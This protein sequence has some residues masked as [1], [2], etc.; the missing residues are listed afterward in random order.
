MNILLINHYA[1]STSYG[2]EYRPFYMARE[3]VKLGHNVTIVGGSYSHVRTEQPEI[4]G[5]VTEENVDGIRYVWLKTP[6][7]RGNGTRRVLNIFSFVF[8][9]WWHSRRVAGDFPP[10]VVIASSTYPLDIFPANRIAE[11]Y[12]A[13]LLFEVH[14]LWPLTPIQIGGMSP[15]HP[16]IML[17]QYA[18][19]YAY[20]KS[21]RVISMLP[22]AFEYMRKHGLV[23][24]KFVHI[25]NGINT[26]EWEG[27]LTQLP[28]RHAECLQSFRN[29]G[30]FIIGYVGGH[31]P[32]NA[33]EA[34]LKAAEL[35]R[36]APAIFV[37]VGKGSEKEHL[38]RSA[39]KR[40][41]SNVVFLPP[42]PKAC[43]PSML[44]N[45]DTLYLGLKNQPLFHYGIS[46]NKLMDYMMAAKPVIHS[47]N[48]GN[49]LVAESGCGISCPGE[50]ARAVAD[51]VLR[52]MKLSTSE[53]AAMG[54][55]GREYVIRHHQYANLARRFLDAMQA[56]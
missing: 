36:N 29:D 13:K 44:A 49:D 35:L 32:S 40:N 34:V 31:Q 27:S 51:A 52:L 19:N 14:D 53:R 48:S 21:D 41:L 10:M 33:L 42:I 46:P 39:A 9:L 20:R 28:P 22:N 11:K 25:P 45:V 55:R 23:E 16:F 4:A 38:Q 7:Y 8:R 54:Q 5:S 2:M 3:W 30:R 15:K 26:S 43:V 12:R 24:E 1:G 50:D 47:V 56:K 6:F 37:L 17:M 18:E